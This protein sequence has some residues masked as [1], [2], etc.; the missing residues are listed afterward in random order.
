MT[1]TELTDYTTELATYADKDNPAEYAKELVNKLL[2]HQKI[3]N[4]YVYYLATGNLKC[5]YSV[6]GYT[7]ADIV[8]WQMDHFKALLDNKLAQN[9]DNSYRMVLEAFDTMMSLEDNP[10]KYISVMQSTTGTDFV[11]KF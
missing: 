11:E 2:A 6:E 8:I 1:L 9:K 5:D 3:L 10:Q 7:I 4:E